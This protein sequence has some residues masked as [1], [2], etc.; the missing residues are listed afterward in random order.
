MLHNVFLFCV[1]LVVVEFGSSLLF[2]IRNMNLLLACVLRTVF[3]GVDM[4]F[5]NRLCCCFFLLSF[6]LHYDLWVC[7]F[8]VFVV[9]CYRPSLLVP[10]DLT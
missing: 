7:D 2:D 3:S 9:L 10:V 6:I 5:R 8:S 1:L 4:N